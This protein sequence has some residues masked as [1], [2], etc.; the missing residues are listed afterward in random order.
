MNN[1]QIL[2]KT[3]EKLSVNLLIGI[4]FKVLNSN[5]R[6]K[7]AGIDIIVY[8][9]DIWIFVELKKRKSDY[10]IRPKDASYQIKKDWIIPRI[11]WVLFR[12]K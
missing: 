4:G 10:F 5:W 9:K 2:G 1:N 8:K 11:C 12:T 3:V 6:Y 7:K